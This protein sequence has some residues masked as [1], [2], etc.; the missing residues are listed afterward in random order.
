MHIIIAKEAAEFIKEKNMDN[1]IYITEVQVKSGWCSVNQ[2][3]VKMGRPDN[4]KAFN[5]YEVGE[6]S[7]YLLRTL[8]IP[9]D[10]VKIS[11]KKILFIKSLEVKGVIV[12]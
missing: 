3:S 5:L 10:E 8:N 2:L 12:R 11:L 6:I 7:V 4:E 9:K 1:S